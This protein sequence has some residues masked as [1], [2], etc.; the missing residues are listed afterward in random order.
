MAALSGWTDFFV[1]ELGAS[2]ALAGLVIVAIS[3]NLERILS[4]AALPGRAA[5]TLVLLTGA[6]TLAGLALMPQTIQAL[7]WEALPLGLLTWLAPLRAHMRAFAAR[8]ND[9]ISWIWSRIVIAQP[10]SLPMIAG[11]VL[12]IGGNAAGAYCFAASIMAALL[13]AM[14]NTWIL[15]VEILR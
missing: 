7:G 2:A 5:E 3:I 15:L 11:A 1:A 13:G 12:L 14:L 8:G 9:P 4:V 10:A 6:L